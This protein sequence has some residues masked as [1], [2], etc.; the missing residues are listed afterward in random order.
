MIQ[1]GGENRPSQEGVEAF[2]LKLSNYVG[3]E[4]GGA[5]FSKSDA[6]SGVTDMTIGHFQGNLS[7]Q[8]ESKGHRMGI[9]AGLSLKGFFHT[10]PEGGTISDER[11]IRASDADFD[12]RNSALKTNPTLYFMII[13]RSPEFNDKTPYKKDYTKDTKSY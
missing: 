5:Y 13:T 4:I 1:V 10:H 9:A 8:S 3:V 6:S 7:R 11:R 12:V 2:A